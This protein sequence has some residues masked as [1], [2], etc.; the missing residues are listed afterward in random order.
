MFIKKNCVDFKPM[1]MDFKANLRFP[2]DYEYE[3]YGERWRKCRYT[4]RVE[5]IRFLAL[6]EQLK[7]AL[8]LFFIII[9]E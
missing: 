1:L 6:L 5:V 9:Y 7:Y 3:K 4:W 2:D 8:L